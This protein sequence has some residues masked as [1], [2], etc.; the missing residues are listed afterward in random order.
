[1]ALGLRKSSPTQTPR[2]LKYVTEF[3]ALHAETHKPRQSAEHIILSTKQH[4]NCVRK[5]T[6]PR[7]T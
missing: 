5:Q 1:M 7:I 4:V 3:T 6:E 2:G